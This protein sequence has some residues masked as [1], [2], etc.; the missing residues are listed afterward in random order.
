MSIRTQLLLA[1]AAVA[2]LAHE[3]RADDGVGMMV[4]ATL[5]KPL[6]EDGT[7][8][9]SQG[10]GAEIRMLPRREPMTLSIGGYYAL[11]QPSVAQTARDIYDF[12]FNVGFK[13]ERSKGSKLIP[14]LS[15]G[16]D[17]L[18]M[19]THQPDGAHYRGT[20]L[21]INAAAGFMGFLSD[22]WIYRVNGAYLGAIVP[23][24]GDDLGG[25]VLQAGIG[26]LFGD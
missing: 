1:T 12:H 17:V 19:N 2:L 9:N 26:R 8:T 25:L 16:L 24:T 3:A 10:A 15:I 5:I 22:R 23:G 20:T 6:G 4:D 7:V 21:G 14:F 13:P 11:G 18:F